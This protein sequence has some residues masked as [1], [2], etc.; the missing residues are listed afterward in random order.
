MST[1]NA[2][3]TTESAR[4]K[5]LAEIDYQPTKPRRQD[6]KI[7]LIGCGGI[8]KD[9]LTAYKQAGLQVVALADLD[10]DRAERRRNEF[11]PNATIYEDHRELLNRADIEV[12]DIATHTDVRAPLI[13]DAISAGKHVLSQK[14]FVLD[15]DLGKELIELAE[16]KGVTLA[17][18]QNGRWAPHFSYARHAVDQGL[19]GTLLSA[20]LTV[21]WDHTWVQGTA[22]E[23]IKHLILFDYA[24]HW[25]DIVSCFFQ[26][27][28]ASRVFASYQ[29]TATQTLQSPLMA[30]VVIEYPTGAAS[31]F[32]NAETRHGAEDRTFL[33]GSDASLTSRG[34][35][36]REQTVTV[37]TALGEFQPK[38]EGCWFPDAFLGSMGELLRSLE[39]Q[40]V[41]IIDAARNLRSLELCFAA[42]ASAESGEPMIPGL[43]RRIDM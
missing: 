22:F 39:E 37:S 23:K 34:P 6:W 33:A 16:K 38:L 17:V 25:F 32:F 11:Y 8:T 4:L 20:N 5:R 28:S 1:T 19:L 12:V 31:L 21:H 42:I 14:P 40:R 43:V 29:Q 7:G 18:N 10:L 13:R 3:S 27:Q 26:Q 9:H 30:Q 15:L 36:D 41:P 35:N 2:S 24:I